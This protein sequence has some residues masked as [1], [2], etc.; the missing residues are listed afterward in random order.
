MFIRCG[1]FHCFETKEDIIKENRQ[2][3]FRYF[4]ENN[5]SYPLIV[6]IDEYGY[7]IKT[8]EDMIKRAEYNLKKW[9]EILDTVKNL[10]Y[11]KEKQER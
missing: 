2:S 5:I 6:T 7:S 10:W 1:E 3:I 4:G 8:K 9:Q 11:N